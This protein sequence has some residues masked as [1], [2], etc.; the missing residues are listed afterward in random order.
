MKNLFLLSGL[1]LLAACDNAAPVPT[2]TETGVPVPSDNT[3]YD[4]ALDA[5]C[6]SQTPTAA[7]DSEEYRAARAAREA[8]EA[9]CEAERYESGRTGN[10]VRIPECAN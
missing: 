6:D 8:K 7:C 1:L 10:P 4:P 3:A 9:E 2:P 5:I